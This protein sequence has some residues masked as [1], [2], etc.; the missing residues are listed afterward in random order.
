MVS[1]D[2]GETTGWATFQKPNSRD[3]YRSGQIK[4]NIHGVWAFLE[5]SCGEVFSQ[6]P[7]VIV[8][9]TFDY[10][11]RLDK[12]N[13]VPVEVIGVIKIWAASH[14]I[15]LKPQHPGQRMWWSDEKLKRSRLYRPGKPHAN[16]AMRHLLTYL[17]VLPP[18]P[19]GR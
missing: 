9:E 7:D 8:F 12:A 13:L 10:R 5:T 11:P 6:Y 17:N 2:P 16:D 15:P 14:D 18:K 1:F 3:G 19:E 4:H